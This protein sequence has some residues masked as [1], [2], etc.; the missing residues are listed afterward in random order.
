[1]MAGDVLA[2]LRDAPL[3]DFHEIAGDAPLLILAP[4]PDDESLGCGGLIAGAC[5][6]GHDIRVAILTDGGM[7]HPRSRAWPRERLIARRAAEAKAAVG[8]LGLPPARLLF[9]NEPDGA[10]AT[11]GP[12]FA[13]AVDRLADLLIRDRIG[14]VF[15]S[16]VADPHC[17]HIAAARI[18]KSACALVGARRLSY[19]VWAWTLPDDADVPDVAGRAMRFEVGCYLP[20]KRRAIECHATQHAGLIDDDPD[21]FTLQGA[22]LAAFDHTTEVFIAEP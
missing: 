20:A 18:A 3:R 8:C 17:D 4:H 19:P 16:W 2:V 10:A 7:S 13:K 9:F 6:R 5:S 14:T 15:S 22:F 1:M 12:E 11:E 21:G